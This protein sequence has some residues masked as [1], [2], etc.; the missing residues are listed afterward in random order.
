[1]RQIAVIEDYAGLV[2]AL[3]DRAER[4]GVS[5]ETVGAIAGLPAGYVGHVLGVRP[6]RRLG[7]VSLGAMLGALGL[8]LAVIEDE[9]GL[10][11]IKPRLVKR[12]R[13]GRH[14]GR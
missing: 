11:R 2:S 10:A 5:N 1:M 3:R 13:K 6:G 7:V 14:R 4:L 12:A 9:A 8:K